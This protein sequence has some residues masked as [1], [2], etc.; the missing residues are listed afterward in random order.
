MLIFGVRKKK[1]ICRITTISL[2]TN[3]KRVSRRSK[4]LKTSNSTWKR[5]SSSIIFTA[6][7]QV[8]LK[9]NRPSSKRK[10]LG[11]PKQNGPNT[12]NFLKIKFKTFCRLSCMDL[13]PAVPHC[14]LLRTP[15][16]C[17]SKAQTITTARKKDNPRK[18]MVQVLHFW[19]NKVL[20]VTSTNQR[21][22]WFMTRQS[23]TKTTTATSTTSIS[24]TSKITVQR[25][26][27]LLIILLFLN[28]SL[29]YY[30]HKVMTVKL[31]WSGTKILARWIYWPWWTWR[32]SF[33]RIKQCLNI[34]SISSKMPNIQTCSILLGKWSYSVIS[35]LWYLEVTH[36]II[37]ALGNSFVKLNSACFTRWVFLDS[38]LRR[39]HTWTRSGSFI[40]MSIQRD[41]IYTMESLNLTW[42]VSPIT[43]KN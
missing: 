16:L 22:C 8:V 10:L 5:K 17:P 35:I 13:P 24:R 11:A 26:K 38:S 18:G 41:Y 2:T 31:W 9:T 40:E 29:T 37:L 33:K 1:T 20:Q 7:D 19:I 25:K 28:D 42:L 15:T 6:R 43:T 14:H 30:I 32:L 39:L 36:R 27:R 12:M 4:H 3:T 23:S 34:H 21:K